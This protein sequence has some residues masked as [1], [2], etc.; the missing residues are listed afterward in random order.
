M[1]VKLGQIKPPTWPSPTVL[2]PYGSNAMII[3]EDFLYFERLQFFT[4]RLCSF[5][6]NDNHQVKAR[7]DSLF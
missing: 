5:E 3:I 7:V 1:L 2:H 4:K 6:N